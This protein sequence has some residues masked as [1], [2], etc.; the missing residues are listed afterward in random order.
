KDPWTIPNPVRK[1]AHGWITATAT[2]LPT[3]SAKAGPT[4]PQPGPAGKQ[5]A[6][7]PPLARKAKIDVIEYL[8]TPNV[9]LNRE[10]VL[11]G[12]EKA[13]LKRGRDYVLRVRNAQG[14]MATLNTI[15]DA[16]VA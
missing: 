12:F 8:E 13:G 10:G 7:L 4:K 9:E 5:H 1:R 15:V 11:A 14:D 16:A 3:F 6:E 2:N